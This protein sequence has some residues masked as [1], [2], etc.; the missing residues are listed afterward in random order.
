M[1]STEISKFKK[2]TS[3]QL[4]IWLGQKLN[5]EVP[6]Y[7]MAHSFDISG[8]LDMDIFSK[9]FQELID[10][11]DV[12]RT[13]FSEIGESPVQS[14]LPYVKYNMEIVDFSKK[15]ENEKYINEWM[16]CRSQRIFDLSKPLFD[17]VLIKIAQDRCIWFLNMHHLV[18]DATSSTILFK[19]MTSLYKH[20]L[21]DDLSEFKQLPN[22]GDYVE[23]EE[24]QSNSAIS[25][26]VQKYW[27][28]KIKNHNE[29]PV[30]YGKDNVVPTSKALRVVLPLGTERTNK[31]KTLAARPEVRSW[32]QDLTLFNLMSTLIFTFIYRVTGNQNVSLGALSHNRSTKTFKQTS[33]LF[34]ALFPI[35][36]QI[37][38]E[39]NFLDVL[40]RVKIETAN[41]LRYT[42]PGMSNPSISKI[43]NVVLNYINAKF[44]DFNGFPMKSEW[45]HPG[46]C[47]PA[48][49][50]RCHVVDFD[51][52]GE[53]TM[54]FDFN[55]AVFDNDLILNA[56]SHFLN[57]FDAFLE[58][59]DQPVNRPNLI[60]LKEKKVLIGTPILP[61]VGY[62]S[63][64]AQFKESVSM[65]ADQ[66]ALDYRNE[67][68]TYTQIDQRSN[69]LASLL[70]TK[71]IGE[72]NRVAIYIH[73]S[74]EYII[75]VL[76]ILKIGGT[77]IP[78][79]S[80]QPAQRIAY[81]L[82]N[83]ETDLILTN[84]S[85]K[86]H[87]PDTTV[88]TVLLDFNTDNIKQQKEEIPEIVIPSS[89]IAYIIYTSGSTGKPKGVLISHGAIYNYLHWAKKTYA[90]GK[91]FVFPL[92]T[93]IGFDLTI[94]AS[95]LPLITGGELV[96]YKENTIGPDISVMEVVTDNKVNSIKL[97]PSH[98]ALLHGM[99]LSHSRIKLM[100]L[101]GE[102]FKIALANTIQKNFGN[103]L[104][105]FN[106]YGPTEATVGCIVSQYDIAKHLGT[107]VPIGSVIDNMRVYLL[108]SQD[109]LV[110]DGVIGEIYLSG[111]GLAEGY[112]NM[113]QLTKEK[114]VPNPFVKGS[115]MYRTGDLARRNRAGELEY[116]GRADEQVKL[117][118]FRI[119][120][121][122][123][124][125]NLLRH[126]DITNAAVVLI[127][128]KK[129][130]PDDEVINCAEC[131]LPSNYPN[132]D[133]DDHD[134]CHLC[135]AFKGYK[136]LAQRYFK[137]ENELR[138][139]LISKRGKS[140]NY[141]CISLLSG[142][143]D[144]TFVVAKLMEMGL[145][146]LAFTLD[147]GY[148][149]EQAKQNIDIIVKKL[150]VDHIYGHTPF[151]NKIFVDSLERHQN[152]C[153]G[154][155]K[156][157]Y[158]LST[159]IALEKKI[160]FVVTGLSRGQFFETRLTE[161]LFWDKNVAVTTIDQTILEA[162]KLYH[163]EEDAVKSLMDVSMFN[164]KET[165][166]K[167]QF[168]DYYRYNDVSLEEMLAFL[169]E[170]V[171]WVRPTDTG[172]STNCLINQLGIYVHK[173]Q[174]GY[175]NY[176]FPYSWDVRM[177]HKTRTETLEEIN[178]HIDETAVK[179]IMKEIGYQ[180]PIHSE[181]GQKRLVAYY[182]GSQKVAQGALSNY[183]RKALPDYM[184]PVHFKYMPEL[185]LT[186]NGKVDKHA[187]KQF[188]S[189]Q[190]EMETP[191]VAPKGEIEALLARIW[192]EVLNLK[193]VGT[194]DNFI[195]LGGHSLAAIRVTARI[196]EEVEMN[197]PLNKI[198][199]LPTISSYAK[200]IETTLIALMEE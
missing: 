199:E 86:Q 105:I 154:C 69:Q 198:F 111:T 155:F 80:D 119:E 31:L 195:V 120:L 91:P 60:S 108:D 173:K 90:L 27:K 55:R 171:G 184:V 3:S 82:Y 54:L 104:K 133:F 181:L 33:G 151:M 50:L 121:S 36:L 83:S 140:P 162:R 48:H 188:N 113:S 42:Q 18:T 39:D 14:I 74:P 129:T 147:N 175:S 115:K 65:C 24:Q 135:N 11:V 16:Q 26:K 168:V 49:H 98:L 148:I 143:K 63:I 141:D 68:Y 192:K 146:V 149:S 46:H 95:F 10:R 47:D 58:D 85:L 15:D 30:L 17:S 20:L 161:E 4:A 52:T 1:S 9:A 160:P 180:E 66:P 174:K 178:E 182:S 12:M 40:E 167:V 64:L 164:N 169:K 183:L 53:I 67:R 150:G 165:F 102:M 156:T 107:S 88:E 70:L 190:L 94:T 159:K 138:D 118:G 41:Y 99:D 109:H 123:I 110:P 25:Q 103:Q 6:L 153:N 136:N 172:R 8:T 176:S 45:I 163:Q 126:H 51:S 131:G 114:F 35:Q 32:T 23:F 19:T 196:N 186:G 145:Q 57:L 177:G 44:N 7:N 193:Q 197:L 37:G 73:R 87:L 71:G 158:T 22:Y 117:G 179:R 56:P 38:E 139:L 185:P 137:T 97:T 157:I 170:K 106:E 5:P 93:S 76:A 62:K 61:T 96:I 122:D 101:G 127:E 28:H 125:S 144:S 13:V 75:G 189:S 2:L 124:E 112:V 130:I 100:I 187:L 89:S 78:I 43:F 79:P 116:I 194:Q 77:F 200:Y 142:G 132:A 92:F 152:V 128:D 59:S 191:Y 81:I 166:D 21:R 29:L 84:T 134:V 34:I 72:G